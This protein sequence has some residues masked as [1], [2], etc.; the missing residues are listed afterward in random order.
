[1]SYVNKSSPK[2]PH[3]GQLVIVQ[4]EEVS[5]GYSSHLILNQAN[6]SLQEGSVVGL[7]GLNGTG[8]TTTMRLIANILSPTS[9]SIGR[10]FAHLGYLPEERGLYRKMT[11]SNYLTFVAALDGARGAV[12][13]ALVRDW[14]SRFGLDVYVNSRI[15]TLSKGNQQKVQ[16]AATMIGKPDLLLWDEPFSGLDA[17]NQELLMDVLQEARQQG[18]TVLLSTHRIDDLETLADATYI[19]AQKHFHTYRRPEQ[20]SA[21]VITTRDQ[22][23]TVSTA[24]L[25][26]LM[27]TLIREGQ[28]IQEVRPQ[29]DLTE[30]FRRLVALDNTP[31]DEVP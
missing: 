2:H 26:A 27:T 11:V 17:L 4:L 23:L 29:S 3:G 15:D 21:Y 13:K 22:H 14:I 16:L 24:D 10:K 5:F 12:A 7:L 28:A 9:G 31:S 6:L 30:V 8:K 25:S 1:M 20:P 18:V 19:L